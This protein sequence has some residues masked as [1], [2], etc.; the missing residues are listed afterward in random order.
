VTALAL[1]HNVTPVV[2]TDGTASYQAASPD[3]VAL[4]KFSESVGLKLHKR[5]EKSITL[6]LTALNTEDAY[7][8]L[9][10]FPFSSTTKRMG[11][12][13][14][15]R[16]T[17]AITFFMKG[18]E[19]VMK[20]KIHYSDWLDEEVD[21]LA[22]IG[23]RTLV[24]ASKPLTEQA[25]VD[26]RRRYLA[27]K[28]VIKNRDA[29]VATVVA[30]LE[31]NMN[32]LGLTGVEDKLQAYVRTSLE[33][34]R[35]AGIRIWMLTGDKA[36]TATCIGISARLVDRGQTV[37]SLLAKTKRDAAAGLDEFSAQVNACLVIDGTAL[38]ICLDNFEKQFLEVA[39]QAPSVICCRCSPT[40]KAVIVALMKQ[41]TGKRCAAIG[42]G[43][44]DVGMIQA[45]D[46]GI[47]I[48]GKEG[49]QASLAADFS[50]DQF[51]FINRLVL[52]HGRNAY[53]RSA[54][55]S[56]FVIHRGLIISV[57]Q[58]VFSAL[59]FYLAIPV[60]NGWLM[61]GYAT[62]YTMFPVFSLVLDEDVDVRQVFMYPE[63]YKE[64]QKGRPLSY[65]TF[66]IWVFL[67]TYQGAVIMIFAIVLFART[68]SNLVAI[69]L[70]ALLPSELVNS[71]MEGH[72]WHI[73]ILVSEVISVMMYFVSMIVLRTYFDITFILTWSFLWKV[74]VITGISTL[75]AALTKYCYRRYSPSAHSKIQSM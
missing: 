15:R 38:Q 66:F 33:T 27:A 75:P 7:D 52:W 22:R 5:D 50:I 64:L 43:G 57:I 17:G 56:Q 30:S 55:L 21:N 37:Y 49:K 9:N 60:Y 1:C 16:S 18:A 59:F 54:R 6:L 73:L 74:L 45:A 19:S 44:N 28:A 51:S 46:V 8:V 32:L 41:Y 62:F 29:Q 69:T 14:R 12:I 20:L 25:Y 34:L 3:E 36:E 67:S 24:V 58:A 11:I 4:V 47:G 40:Q 42:D 63:L 23:L 61:V 72:K 71:A 70:T 68:L 31:K 39:M 48:V 13:V 35:N 10:I 26:F 65:K 2:E 53:K